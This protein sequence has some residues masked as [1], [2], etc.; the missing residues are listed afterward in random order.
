MTTT[1]IST[2]TIVSGTGFTY[3]AAGDALV[4]LTNITL[5]STNGTAI[6]IP[7]DD[8]SLTVLGT[9]VTRDLPT[10]LT[11]SEVTIARGGSWISNQPISSSAGIFFDGGASIFTNDGTLIARETIGV[12]TRGGGNV[13]INTGSIHG[14]SN[15]VWLGLGAA[16]INESLINSGTISSGSADDAIR[17]ARY[18]NGVFADSN[19]T[20]ITNL[21]SGTITA[22]S[23]EGA[24]IRFGNGANGSL[25]VN[26]GQIISDR[27]S[28]V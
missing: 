19:F 7:F 5:G 8:T 15:G 25:L 21:A 20:R 23:S 14:G 26:F 27:T 4:I 9:V 24:G 16:S 12:L 3:A 6:S 13:V 28:V 1:I 22:V 11:G 10:F 2:N 17:D 18:N